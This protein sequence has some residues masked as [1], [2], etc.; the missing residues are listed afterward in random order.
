MPALYRLAA[1]KR[2]PDG[3]AIVG[4]AHSARSDDEFR[5]HLKKAIESHVSEKLDPA[6]VSWL[7]ERSSYVKGEFEDPAAYD[8]LEQALDRVETAR[9]IPGNRV[10]YLATPPAAF[11]PIV[12]RL[13][14]KGMAREKSEQQG[15]RRVVVEKPF[16]TDVA[17]AKVLNRDLLSVFAESQIYRIDHFLGKETVQNIMA[18]RF[19]NGIFESLWNRDRIDHVQIT[20][21][22]TVAVEGRGKFYDATGALRDMVPNHLVPTDDARSRW[23][24]RPASSPTRCAPKKPKCCMPCI[25]SPRIAR[26]AMSCAGNTAR[27][28]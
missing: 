23:S 15:W 19:A 1:Q 4:I 5:Q 27:A 22:E 9:Q 26:C 25:P 8:R 18:L 16:G 28:W 13:G 7:I 14:E 21:A 24:R 6:T 11:A 3:F 2:L 20:A 10:Y 17:S 12:K